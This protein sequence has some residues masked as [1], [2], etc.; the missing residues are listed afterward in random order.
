MNWATNLML[1]AEFEQQASIRKI[2]IKNRRK[3]RQKRKRITQ[4]LFKVF[5][6]AT[7]ASRLGLCLSAASQRRRWQIHLRA[8][9]S[10]PSRPDKF[11]SVRG[12]TFFEILKC[13]HLQRTSRSMNDVVANMRLGVQAEPEELD[14]SVETCG[15]L[16]SFKCCYSDLLPT[17]FQAFATA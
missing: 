4:Q 8:R 11:R 13:F 5:K 10:S 6:G 16:R 7:L 15:E 9:S 12:S 2:F 1:N 3:K 17:W 14:V